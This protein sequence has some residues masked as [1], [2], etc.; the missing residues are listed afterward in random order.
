MPRWSYRSH[1]GLNT[2]IAE[3]LLSV[4]NLSGRQTVIGA[5]CY[6]NKAFFHLE[7][8]QAVTLRS[9]VAGLTIMSNLHEPKPNA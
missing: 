2:C 6:T 7:P 1:H 5:G 3:S 8:L 9:F 4:W